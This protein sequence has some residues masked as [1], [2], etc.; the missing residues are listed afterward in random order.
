M[1]NYINENSVILTEEDAEEFMSEYYLDEG[2]IVLEGRQAEEYLKRKQ[3]E[4]NKNDK[5]NNAGRYVKYGDHGFRSQYERSDRTGGI[6][7]IDVDDRYR[8]SDQNPRFKT[9]KEIEEH[10]KKIWGCNA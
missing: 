7:V 10:R 6:K 4:K 1:A 3:E 8:P 2:Y 9:A 5:K